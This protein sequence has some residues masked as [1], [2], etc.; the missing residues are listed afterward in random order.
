MKSISKELAKRAKELGIC[1]DWHERLKSTDDKR[2]MITM[3]IKGIDFCLANDYPDNDYIVANFG[4]IMHDFG[5]FVDSDIDLKNTE[6]CIALGKTRGKIEVTD[7]NVCE[8]FVKHNSELTII[9]KDNAFVVIDI[10][11]NSTIHIQAQNNAKICI[12]KYIG[13]IIR[14]RVQIDNAVIKINEK[15]KK[16]YKS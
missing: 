13:A 5:I 11:N 4:E 14:G 10:F 8:I 2:E 16:S 3:Y 15:P 12:N 9:A 1:K 7:Y 6:R